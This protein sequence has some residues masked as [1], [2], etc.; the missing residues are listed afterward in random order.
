M[1]IT[2]L[3]YANVN[4]YLIDGDKKILFDTG[5]AGSFNE[6]CRVMGENKCRLQD[7]DYLFISHFHPDHMGIAQEIANAGAVIVVFDV[8]KEYIHSAD[9]IF[10]KE[11]RNRFVPIDDSKVKILPISDSREFLSE[12]GINGEVFHTPG[13]SD[14]SISLW[15]DDDQALFVGD[16]APLYELDAH[17][18]TQTAETWEKLLA[19]KPKTVYYGHARTAQLE[20]E[21]P[22]SGNKP[23]EKDLYSLVR[24]ITKLLNKGFTVDE[25][26]ARTGADKVF[27]N[28]AARMYVTHPGVSVQG[29]LD[30]IEIKGK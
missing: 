24:T 23:S 25:I 3:H 21:V 28:D 12:C 22:R 15:L 4:T 6:L 11:K 5:W 27:V 7:T 10:E 8:Q 1:M 20:Q 17:K 2:L 13:H 29:I 30:R 9:H 18:G 16:L 14:D 26:A 19:L